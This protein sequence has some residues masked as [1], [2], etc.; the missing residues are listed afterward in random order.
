[1]FRI[2]L[3]LFTVALAL[4]SALVVGMADGQK[5]TVAPGPD[6]PIKIGG[7]FALTGEEACLDAAAVDG[8]KLATKEINARGKLL[9]RTVELV[10]LD[11]HYSEDKAREIAGELVNREKV[12]AVIGYS[13]T[14]SALASGPVI[15]A[16]GIPFVTVGATSPELP[17]QIGDMMFLACFGDNEQAAAGAEFSLRQ[18]GRT[19]CLLW[20]EERDYTVLL[21]SYFKSSFLQQGGT[22]LA[23]DRFQD[24][25]TDLSAQIDRIKALPTKPDFYYVAAMPYNAGLVVK[26]LR[27]A[28]I[29]GP[30]VGG[31]GYDT[32]DLISVAGPASENVFFTT[33]AL[34]DPVKGP[35][36]V[37]NFI[38]AFEAEYGRK[39]PNAFA[40]LGYDTV[41]LVVD[42]VKRAG[43]TD[44]QAIR[45]ALENTVN[46]PCITGAVN[47]TPESHVPYKAVTVIRVKD[48]QF[49]LAGE[50][51]PAQVP[52][53]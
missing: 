53:P 36:S 11:S 46:F 29:S 51:I 16:A 47:F 34:M 43:T 4:V 45:K 44:G 25:V 13:E 17:G 32:P 1:M 50:I 18:F 14:D 15:Q 23:E 12:V 19:A 52:D 28:G 9:G 27:K 31:D 26:Q 49:T 6:E 33:H 37:R 22:I 41:R 20:D 24:K 8:A 3:V 30:I 35:E 10:V 38:A 5:T 40:A 7:A 39:P 2:R 21:G 42:A 48:G